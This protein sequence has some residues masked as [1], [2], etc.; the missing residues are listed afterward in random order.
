M[1]DRTGETGQKIGSRRTGHKGKDEPMRNGRNGKDE[2]GD[3]D[4]IDQP[5]DRIQEWIFNMYYF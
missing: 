5:S 4:G 1:S 2:R 3:T